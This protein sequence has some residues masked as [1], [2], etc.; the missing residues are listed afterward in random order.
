MRLRP[1]I[2]DKSIEVTLVDKLKLR[3]YDLVLTYEWQL[4]SNLKSK[5]TDIPTLLALSKSAVTASTK[6]LTLIKLQPN[7]VDFVQLPNCTRRE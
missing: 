3:S 2:A 4:F 1:S 5:T 6:T 7:S